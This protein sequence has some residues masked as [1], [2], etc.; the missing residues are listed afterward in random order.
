M[1]L[2]LSRLII[3]QILSV[4]V[5]LHSQI[6]HAS[7]DRAPLLGGAML[8]FSAPLTPNEKKIFGPGWKTATYTSAQGEKF[9]LFPLEELTRAGGVIFG[10]SIRLRISST[11]KYATIDMLRVGVIDPGPSGNPVV[12]SR[13][14]CP[15][16]ETKTGCIVSDQSGEF[17]AGQWGKQGDRW[18]VPGVMDEVSGE[19][20]KHQFK[21]ANALW[22]EY[23][24]SVGK[25]FHLSIREVI[26]SNFG[27]YNLMAC[28]RL[29]ENNVA[30][31][32]NIAEELKK[33]GDAIGSE[34]IAKKLQGMAV[35]R[36]RNGL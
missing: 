5:M 25:P 2:N 32:K 11:G 22:R 36:G 3:I 28:D 6:C 21:D 7:A 13:Q 9:N 19:M 20:L 10:D 26:S 15:V 34:Y 31:Y 4:A 14:Y 16:L 35:L 29:G 12:Q 30:S 27:I 1:Q 24:N 33:A 17:C 8:V 23:V 18:I